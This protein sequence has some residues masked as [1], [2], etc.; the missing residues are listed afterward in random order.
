MKWPMNWI[1]KKP[2]H[3]MVYV[4]L[5]CWCTGQDHRMQLIIFIFM[6][7]HLGFRF[8]LE[9]SIYVFKG[10]LLWIGCKMDVKFKDLFL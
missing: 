5:F 4:A 10:T 9:S 7:S 1:K 3:V 6:S 2:A 8:L